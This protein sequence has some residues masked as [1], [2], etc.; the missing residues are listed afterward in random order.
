MEYLDIVDEQGQPTGKIIS[1][2][3]Q[4]RSSDPR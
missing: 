3:L 2:T 4:G 1:R